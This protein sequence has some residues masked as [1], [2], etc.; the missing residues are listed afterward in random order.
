MGIGLSERARSENGYVVYYVVNKC[1][2]TLIECL[3][4]PYGDCCLD[5]LLRFFCLVLV[6]LICSHYEPLHA[7]M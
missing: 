7:C 4:F 5:C 6:S 2:T 1:V 3:V